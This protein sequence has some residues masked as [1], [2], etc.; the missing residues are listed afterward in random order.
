MSNWKIWILVTIIYSIVYSFDMVKE[1]QLSKSYDFNDFDYALFVSLSVLK[2]AF[3]NLPFL[4][5][6]KFEKDIIKK[7]DLSIIWKRVFVFGLFSIMVLVVP[8]IFLGN[9][10]VFTTSNAICLIASISLYTISLMK[11]NS[12]RKIL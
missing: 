1:L 7:E 5:F 6:S 10:N 8:Y 9:F 3:F 4:L 11:L 12:H 2:I